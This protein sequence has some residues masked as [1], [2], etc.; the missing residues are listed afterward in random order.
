MLYLEELIQESKFLRYKCRKKKFNFRFFLD[1]FYLKHTLGT[2]IH[3]LEIQIN[4]WII[5][6][7][8]LFPENDVCSQ[9]HT[10]IE[11]HIYSIRHTIFSSIISFLHT[12][13]QFDSYFHLKRCFLLS[14][15]KVTLVIVLRYHVQKE[16][17][18]DSVIAVCFSNVKVKLHSQMKAT[19]LRKISSSMSRC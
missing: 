3:K 11:L 13:H 2:V 4:S 15:G 19:F 7:K 9:R 16:I 10:C 12:F 18:N 5:S 8:L 17:T 14:S 6:F 1:F